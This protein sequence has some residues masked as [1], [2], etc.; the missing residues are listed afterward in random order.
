[1]TMPREGA[2]SEI[3]NTGRSRPSIGH[4]QESPITIRPDSTSRSRKERNPNEIR[5]CTDTKSDYCNASI[6]H[7]ELPLASSFNCRIHLSKI[8]KNAVSRVSGAANKIDPYQEEPNILYM[9][10]TASVWRSLRLPRRLRMDEMCIGTAAERNRD[11]C[12]H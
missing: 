7:F 3:W 2:S 12:E 6:R 8:R 5:S 10:Q 4:V 11:R 9:H 1:M